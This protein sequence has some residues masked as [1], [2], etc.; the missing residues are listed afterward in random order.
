[1]LHSFAL[2]RIDL[3][4][5]TLAICI[6]LPSELAVRF[7]ALWVW[8]VFRRCG[9]DCSGFLMLDRVRYHDITTNDRISYGG[10][11]L[12][13]VLV[14]IESYYCS[15]G[16]ST[17][18]MYL[19]GNVYAI[20]WYLLVIVSTLL[21]LKYDWRLHIVAISIDGGCKAIGSIHLV[22]EASNIDDQVNKLPASGLQSPTI[23]SKC[24]ESRSTWWI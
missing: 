24:I 15:K 13:A 20:I 6:R 1:M 16:A 4:S 10:Y 22:V 17:P 12:D 7:V 23:F 11:Q 18:K 21:A 9:L 2:A 3:S 19:L 5:R 8:Q 14:S